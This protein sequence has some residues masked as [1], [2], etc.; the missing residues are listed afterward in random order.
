MKNFAFMASVAAATLA[1]TT[2]GSVSFPESAAAQS[3]PA[4][5]P[6]K[7]P[8]PQDFGTGYRMNWTQK[9][10]EL[11]KLDI[12]DPVQKSYAGATI[13]AKCVVR[14]GKDNAPGYF[15]GPM[16][17]DPN[18]KNL[19]GVLTGKYSNC[20]EPEVSGVPMF[21]VNA[22]LAEQ[23]LLRDKP[24]LSDKPMSLNMDEANA[25]YL[26][27]GKIT[28]HDALARCVA[29]NSPGIVMKFL[30]T[31]PGS[32]EEEE[33]LKTTFA[34]TPECGVATPPDIANVEH[35]EMLATGLYEWITFH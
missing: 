29:V 18:Y 23:L 32:T 30:E 4:P 25:F 26:T 28:S 6:A 5:T 19:S 12:S 7:A 35:R 2:L 3:T 1:V 31:Q 8:P 15:G 9:L 34:S 24:E 14:R 20:L 17:S 11:K 33:A 22:A 21:V 27:D 16:T 13:M 10:Y